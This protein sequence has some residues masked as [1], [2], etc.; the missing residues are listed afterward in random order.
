MQAANAMANMTRQTLTAAADG[1]VLIKDKLNLAAGAGAPGSNSS[2]KSE[3]L[4]YVYND[5]LAMPSMAQSQFLVG[6]APGTYIKSSNS[7]G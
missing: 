3:M 6:A 5:A 4:S 1:Y 7:G 2:D